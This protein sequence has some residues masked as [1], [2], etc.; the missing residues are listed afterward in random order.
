MRRSAVVIEN[1]EST[2][3][4][5]RSRPRRTRIRLLATERTRWSASWPR[6]RLPASRLSCRDHSAGRRQQTGRRHRGEYGWPCGPSLCGGIGRRAA[7]GWAPGPPQVSPRAST[8]RHPGQLLCWPARNR[9]EVD[10]TQHGQTHWSI[11]DLAQYVA[12]HPE[13]GL[14]IQQEH[15]GVI[16][17]GT[18]SPG[19]SLAPG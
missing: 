8:C 4:M 15:H 2:S 12:A 5:P 18:S 14:A 3:H 7:P 19:P 16:L 1:I 9:P 10:P 13:L 17:S 11:N 6:V